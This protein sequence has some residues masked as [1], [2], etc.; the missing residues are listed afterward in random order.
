MI[1]LE[2]NWGEGE[3][4]RSFG[5]EKKRK[6]DRMDERVLRKHESES[7]GIHED[8]QEVDGDEGRQDGSCEARKLHLGLEVIKH[9]RRSR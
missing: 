2:G 6:G 4:Q 7:V 1:S 8:D 5:E 9:V 3:V